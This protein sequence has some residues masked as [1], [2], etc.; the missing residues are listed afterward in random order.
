VEVE[1]LAGAG[2]LDVGGQTISPTLKGW[3][4]HFLFVLDIKEA[5]PCSKRM[6]VVQKRSL[7]SAARCLAIRYMA[8]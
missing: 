2:C 1:L 4:M 3:S 6:C 7:A 5:L 8:L